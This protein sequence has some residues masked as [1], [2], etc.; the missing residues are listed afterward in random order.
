M[1]DMIT[2]YLACWNETD[3]E[4][5]LALLD[6]HWSRSATYVDPLVAVTGHDD[7]S[8]AIGAVHEQTRRARLPIDRRGDVMPLPGR[9]HIWKSHGGGPGNAVPGFQPQLLV[10]GV[11]RIHVKR[12]PVRIPAARFVGPNRLDVCRGRI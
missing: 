5:R 4:A 9:D 3:A 10:G 11:V 1:S 6:R 12:E 7:L 2:N 8:A